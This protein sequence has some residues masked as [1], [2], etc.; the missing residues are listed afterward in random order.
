MRIY[1]VSVPLSSGTPTYPGD[2]G[3]EVKQW[4]SLITGDSAN[5]SL[6]HFGAHSGTH[7]DAP[8]HFI[9]DAPKSETLPLEILI[10]EALLVEVPNI[11][12]VID[13]DFVA[14]NCEAGITR[15]L[16]KTRNS[17]F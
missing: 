10:G 17:A 1:D 9:A 14:M 15:I 16:F 2:P 13:E 7:V 3:I 6:I 11:V 4:K 5:V 12:S 8:A